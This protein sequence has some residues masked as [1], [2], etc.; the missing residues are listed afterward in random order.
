MTPALKTISEQKLEWLESL[1]RP[2]TSEESDEL[3]RALHAVYC[4]QR[5]SATLAQHRNEE[6]RLLAKV[7]AECGRH[8]L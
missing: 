2:L 5:K 1:R 8:D 7:E 6:L 3:R 4:R